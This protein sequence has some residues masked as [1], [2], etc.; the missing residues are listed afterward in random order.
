MDIENIKAQILRSIYNQW[1]S[2]SPPWMMTPMQSFTSDV[3]SHHR[4][5]RNKGCEVE[6]YPFE[7]F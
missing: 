2:L 5:L 4:L 3:K 1:N 6:G 7:E